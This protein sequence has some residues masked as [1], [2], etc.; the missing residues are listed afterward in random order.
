MQVT[1]LS[2]EQM[3]VPC[4]TSD[5][6][7]ASVFRE[8]TFAL[9]GDESRRLSEQIAALNFRFRIS[10]TDYRSDFHVAGDPTLLLILG[11]AV[12]LSLANGESRQFNVGDVFIAEDFLAEGVDFIDGYHGHKAEVIGQ[13][14]LKA[15]HLKLSRR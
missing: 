3:L 10:G 15:L 12:E 2:V 1:S 9:S 8:K 7:G 11:G 14:Q 13:Q 4:V 5:G 6:R